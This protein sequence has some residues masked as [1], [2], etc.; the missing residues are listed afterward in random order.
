MRTS[1]GSRIRDHAKQNGSDT[2][3]TFR[4]QVYVYGVRIIEDGVL[5]IDPSQSK[6]ALTDD[7]AMSALVGTPEGRIFMGGG[8]GILYELDHQ[9]DQRA[10]LWGR[11]KARKVATTGYVQQ[12]SNSIY[13]LFSAEPRPIVQLLYLAH[14]DK[15]ARLTRRGTLYALVGPKA[16]GSSPGKIKVF[17][18]DETAVT[19]LQ[20]FELHH[21]RGGAEDRQ[22]AGR[23]FCPL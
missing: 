10:W 23:G 21:T 14:R 1:V 12:L 6:D 15:A 17:S 16:D 20:D 5:D 7:V 8:D 13:N 19:E 22:Q 18:I 11:S 9:N 4:P 2:K 3:P